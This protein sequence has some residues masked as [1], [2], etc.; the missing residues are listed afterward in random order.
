[1]AKLILHSDDFG[2]HP[3]INQTV[4]QAAGRGVLTSCSLMV[5]GLA[6]E[7]AVKKALEIPDL[8][9]GLHLNILRGRPL[10]DPE[11]IPSLVDGNGRFFNS[12]ARLAEQSFIKRISRTEV[13]E[14]FRRQ[15][16]CMIQKGIFPTH[17]DSEKHT[18]LWLPEAAWA[19]GRI[20]KDY[21]ISK[22]RVIRETPMLKRLRQSNII[23][24]GRWM[25]RIKLMLLEHRSRRMQQYWAG[26][27]HPDYSFGVRIS[28]F[29]G[30]I[31]FSDI[32]RVFFQMKSDKV[33][34]WMF[35]LDVQCSDTYTEM[36]EEFGRYF[37]TSEREH[38]TR[39]LLSETMVT[40]IEKNKSD[41]VSYRQL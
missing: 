28:G 35:H 36:E 24:R 15:V 33:I 4:L 37:L 17:V 5:N 3:S 11:S 13:Y 8:G 32:A 6:A 31:A 2:L 26:A 29:P 30:D 25:Q 39:M 19:A 27:K 23:V 14:E 18:H 40:E 16:E 38:E 21:G 41:I 34:E 7:E 12:A 22:V 1:M 10:S 20:I 9:V